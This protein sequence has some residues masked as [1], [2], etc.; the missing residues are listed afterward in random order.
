MRTS[1]RCCRDPGRRAPPTV[2]A[3]CTDEESRAGCASGNENFGLP[4]AAGIG[5]DQHLEHAVSGAELNVATAVTA[6]RAF[7]RRVFER[8]A[9]SFR[10]FRS[11]AD[12]TEDVGGE[13]LDERR[14]CSLAGKFEREEEV[15]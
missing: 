12:V 7:S 8:L 13:I 3:C 14:G 2:S 9:Q 15:V 5:G 6:E 4:D 11:R 1:E 10:V